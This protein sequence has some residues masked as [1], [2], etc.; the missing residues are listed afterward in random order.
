MPAP[1]Y[2]FYIHR[3]MVYVRSNLGINKNKFIKQDCHFIDYA[4][5]VIENRKAKL[6]YTNVRFKIGL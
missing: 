6:I 4:L 3:G 2:L 1:G 5:R